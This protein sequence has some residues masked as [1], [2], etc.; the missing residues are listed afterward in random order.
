MHTALSYLSYR[1]LTIRIARDTLILTRSLDPQRGNPQEH[2][3][4]PKSAHQLERRQA[5]TLA[6]AVKLYEGLMSSFEALREL[7]LVESD[8]DLAQEIEAR[9]EA[10]Q[11]RRCIRTAETYTI[12]GKWTEA[13]RVN[14]HAVVAVRSAASAITVLPKESQSQSAVQGLKPIQLQDLEALD[15]EV[16]KQKEDIVKAAFKASQSGDD[17][18][19]EQPKIFDIAFNYVAAFD[20]DALKARAEGQTVETAAEPQA[21]T[22]SAAPVADS[23]SQQQPNA[24]EQ[25]KKGFWG[26]FSRS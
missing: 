25:G 9:L 5:R 16:S 12:L 11:A 15:A 2:H 1:L 26:L 14:E 18:P 13:L 4:K 24:K 8:L 10:T 23:A 21:P 3:S 7:D 6:T 20:I 22:A 19:A 17:R